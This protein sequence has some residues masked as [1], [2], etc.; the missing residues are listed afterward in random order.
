MVYVFKKNDKTLIKRVRVL[1]LKYV[2]EFIEAFIALSIIKYILLGK[3]DFKKVLIYS[4]LLATITTI[5]ETYNPQYKE[6][7]KN[8]FFASGISQI[9]RAF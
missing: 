5:L 8:S 2:N 9:L 6:N 7:I 4:V 3:Y 1:T